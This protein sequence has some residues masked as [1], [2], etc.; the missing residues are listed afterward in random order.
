[1]SS[2]IFTEKLID[3]QKELEIAVM[4][5]LLQIDFRDVP[6]HKVYFEMGVRIMQSRRLH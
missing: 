5:N 3:Y 4:K 2:A 1:M 6:K